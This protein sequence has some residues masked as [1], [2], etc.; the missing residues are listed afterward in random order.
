MISVPFRTPALRNGFVNMNDRAMGALARAYP[1]L[2]IRRI[3]PQLM[4]SR[5][6]L[7]RQVPNPV[8]W[9]PPSL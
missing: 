7:D 1:E 3:Y 2:E 9:S 4:T 5:D 6:E 8:L